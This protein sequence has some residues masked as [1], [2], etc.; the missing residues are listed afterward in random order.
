MKKFGLIFGRLTGAS[1]SI[2][3]AGQS[4][5]KLWYSST[6]D[7]KCLA[8]VLAYTRG[9]FVFFTCDD[10]WRNRQWHQPRVPANETG[11][12]PD[13]LSALIVRARQCLPATI[14][15][16][17]IDGIRL[18]W[19]GLV[20]SHLTPHIMPRSVIQ[21]P[22]FLF[23]FL[24]HHNDN[25]LSICFSHSWPALINMR[26]LAIALGCLINGGVSVI[27]LPSQLGSGGTGP[28]GKCIS[29]LTCILY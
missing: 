3:S 25:I 11:F 2:L 12:L 17:L 29:H 19:I 8:G 26:K 6:G 14:Q 9:T 7:T 18:K 4:W 1:C 23:L 16:C 27:W 15:K 13:I 24:C 10:P 20:T 22:V 28:K 5:T 21:H